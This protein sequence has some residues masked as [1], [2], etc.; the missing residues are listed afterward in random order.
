MKNLFLILFMALSVF[1]LSAQ[2]KVIQSQKMKSKILNKDILYSA[3]LPPNFDKLKDYPVIY[4][5]HGYGNN[6]TT[7][8]NDGHIEAK[9]NKAIA[10][11]IIPPSV[12][13]MPNGENSWYVNAKDTNFNWENMFIKELMPYMEKEYKISPLKK[14]CTIWGASMGGFGAL[15]YAMT[16]PD[17]FGT[18]VAFSPAIYPD[19]AI[20]DRYQVSESP[21]NIIRNTPI[22][23]LAQVRYYIDCGDKDF[24]YWGNANLHILMSDYKINH[25][26]RM[27]AGKH[28]WIYW[29]DGVEPALQFITE[30]AK[31]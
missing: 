22:E 7:W 31:Q 29:R 12:V 20:G 8:L 4:L 16:Y 10:N 25:E 6:E 19:I 23:K 2:G 1:N 11:N 3:Y 27:R 26:F 5:L 15:K 17:K 13:I 18:C 9:M 14:N 24:L 21:L 30:T 28:G